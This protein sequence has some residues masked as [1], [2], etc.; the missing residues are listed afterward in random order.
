[1][2]IWL[3]NSLTCHFLDR[4]YGRSCRYTPPAPWHVSELSPH[5]SCILRRLPDMHLDGWKSSQTVNDPATSRE[6]A[7]DQYTL[8]GG[9]SLAKF[10]FTFHLDKSL[11]R[12][13]LSQSRI[14]VQTAYTLDTR[15]NKHVLL[16]TDDKREL[17]KSPT[18]ISPE[19][20]YLY[21]PKMTNV[22]KQRE[23]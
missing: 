9:R 15:L 22:W 20:S 17:K 3:R 14:S 7:T 13:S 11:E 16:R 23:K 1:M 18:W 10:Y 8:A 4:R 12:N 19:T 2:C 5:T 21:T 6:A